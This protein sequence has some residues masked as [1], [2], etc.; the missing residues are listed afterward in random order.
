MDL[1]GGLDESQAI[2]PLRLLVFLLTS[3]HASLAEVATPPEPRPTQ[4]FEETE[5]SQVSPWNIGTYLGSG[6][7]ASVYSDFDDAKHVIKVPHRLHDAKCGSGIAYEREILDKLMGESVENVPRVEGVLANC[8]KLSPVGISAH[9]FS[10]HYQTSHPPG[11]L[12]R[13]IRHVGPVLV[14]TLERAHGIGIAHCDIRRQNILL[15]PPDRSTLDEFISCMLE[16]KGLKEFLSRVK[17]NIEACSVVLNDWGNA[18]FTFDEDLFESDLRSLVTACLNMGL[19]YDNSPR[20]RDSKDSA[21]VFASRDVPISVQSQGGSKG[22]SNSSSWLREK[23]EEEA[24]L[25]EWASV[26]D[27]DSL[28]S[29]F[30]S[31]P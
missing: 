19:K 21:P 3:D 14:E 24:M 27:Y 16:P 13:F 15:V 17:N 30:G 10:Q 2:S 28:S 5:D 11:E 25:L 12:A 6:A 4:I 31:L 20:L 18:T 22:G 1:S 8:L 9:L 7:S 23:A 29:Y 26:R